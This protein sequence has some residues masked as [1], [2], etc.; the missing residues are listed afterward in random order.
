MRSSELLRT[1]PHLHCPLL[2][3]SVP[4]AAP[5]S[6]AA[7]IGVVDTHIQR[8]MLRFTL[9]FVALLALLG[10]RCLADAPAPTNRPLSALNDLRGPV[11]IGDAESRFERIVQRIHVGMREAEVVA[12]LPTELLPGE[13]YALSVPMSR[14]G[15]VITYSLG[16]G[17]TLRV[18]YAGPDHRV[19]GPVRL[20]YSTPDKK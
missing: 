8:T 19:T 10:H 4:G 9:F 14:A 13:P 7:E 11:P 20:Q 5:C 16:S 18:T 3:F 2:F 12:M 1:L 6:A 17:Y 15:S